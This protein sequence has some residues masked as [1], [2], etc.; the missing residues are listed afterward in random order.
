MDTKNHKSFIPSGVRGEHDYF[1]ISSGIFILVV[2]LHFLRIFYGWD[3][4]VGDFLVPNIL[5]WVAILVAGYMSYEGLKYS[6]K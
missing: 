2:S 1:V 3:L 6:K 5:S 4:Y